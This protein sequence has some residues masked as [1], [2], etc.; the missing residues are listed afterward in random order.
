MSAHPNA[1]KDS[2]E[3]GADNFIAKPFETEELL[4]LIGKYQE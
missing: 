4:S 2:E 3:I 1:K